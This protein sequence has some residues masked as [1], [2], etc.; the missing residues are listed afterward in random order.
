MKEGYEL[1]ND[2]IIQENNET[3]TDLVKPTNEN[4]QAKSS[5]KGRKHT[6]KTK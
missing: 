4:T 3:N 2:N 1:A 5:T 6:K